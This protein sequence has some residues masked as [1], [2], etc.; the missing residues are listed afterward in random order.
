MC[1]V[2]LCFKSGESTAPDDNDRN[3]R[4][5]MQ[6]SR[7]HHSDD[8]SSEEDT[9]LQGAIGQYRVPQILVCPDEE[10]GGYA[11][12]VDGHLDLGEFFFVI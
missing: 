3:V 9:K 2:L 8:V 5:D 12:D 7:K 11:E 1:R 4:I 10:F 6:P